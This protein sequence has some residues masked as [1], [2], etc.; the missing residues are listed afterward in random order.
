VSRDARFERD[1]ARAAMELA[2]EPLPADLLAL[3]AAR[4]R[5]RSPTRLG[6]VI[7]AASAA[8]VVAVWIGARLLPPSGGEAVLR[9]PDAIADDLRDAGYLCVAEAKP[10]SSGAPSGD[11][12][13]SELVCTTPGVL[14]P[15]VGA[16]VL[17]LDRGGSLVAAHAKAGVAGESTAAGE[18]ARDTLLATYASIAFADAGDAAAA[19]AWLSGAL[20]VA[21]SSSVSTMV[22][23][24]PLT[25]RRDATT[26]FELLVGGTEGGSGG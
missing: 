19:R 15:A 3:P 1:L 24:L 2:S 13:G 11:E 17:E 12:A 7:L 18:A 20:M 21:P 26:G 23:G 22:H 16:F 9:T 8:V 5:R 25:L 10:G 14:R 4:A 6:G